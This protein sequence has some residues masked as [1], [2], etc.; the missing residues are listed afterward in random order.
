MRLQT[1]LK[2]QISSADLTRE[3][4]VV[5]RISNDGRVVMTQHRHSKLLIEQENNGFSCEV[6]N[7]NSSVPA[8]MSASGDWAVYVTKAGTIG[9]F[10]RCTHDTDIA[11][12]NGKSVSKLVG[13]STVGTTFVAI[14]GSEVRI[15]RRKY[16]PLGSSTAW[17]SKPL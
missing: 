16:E 9:V 6:S 17:S 11:L 13:I 4:I 14:V 10:F 3:A 12:E 5:T 15:F 2:Q 1:Q 8:L 7:V